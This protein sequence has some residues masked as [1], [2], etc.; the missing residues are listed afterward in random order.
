M[1][2]DERG[3]DGWD[4]GP[5]TRDDCCRTAFSG[6]RLDVG[7]DGPCQWA[8]GRLLGGRLVGMVGLS[9]VGDESTPSKLMALAYNRWAGVMSETVLRDGCIVGAGRDVSET[10]GCPRGVLDRWETVG[11]TG[12]LDIFSCGQ[13]SWDSDSCVA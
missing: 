1:S 3:V 13:M 8:H 12:V 2:E 9:V 10:A 4:R 5:L 6:L 7:C 11:R